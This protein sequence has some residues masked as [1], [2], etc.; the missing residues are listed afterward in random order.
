[1]L[2]RNFNIYL[3]KPLAIFG[4]IFA[5]TF[6]INKLPYPT[7]PPSNQHNKP[8]TKPSLCF[9]VFPCMYIQ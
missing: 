3:T 8:R 6:P 7:P 9:K 1:M 2:S 5:M 4:M